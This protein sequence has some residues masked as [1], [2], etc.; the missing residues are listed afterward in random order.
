LSGTRDALKDVIK[1]NIPTSY[2][3]N[4]ALKEVG[5]KA[6]DLSEIV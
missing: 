1:I 2:G 4:G 6:G 5:A 3:S